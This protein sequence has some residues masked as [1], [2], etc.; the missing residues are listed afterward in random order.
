[1]G[2]ETVS[3][4]VVHFERIA[5]SS[6]VCCRKQYR[7]LKDQWWGVPEVFDRQDV[8]EVG[9]MLIYFTYGSND[10]Y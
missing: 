7:D 4:H 6:Y 9:R 2:S 3:T 1:M 8:V 10:N 5:Q